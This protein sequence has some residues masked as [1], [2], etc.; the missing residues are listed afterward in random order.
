MFE[1][2]IHFG[3]QILKMNEYTTR[4]SSIRN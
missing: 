3:S 2:V 1:T 4:K